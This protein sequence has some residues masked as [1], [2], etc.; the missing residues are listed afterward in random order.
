MHPDL[1]GRYPRERATNEKSLQT[2]KSYVDAMVKDRQRQQPVTVRF[3]LK[4]SNAAADNSS[5]AAGN[6]SHLRCVTSI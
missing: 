6:R 4:P 1:F 5:T 3:F 2:L